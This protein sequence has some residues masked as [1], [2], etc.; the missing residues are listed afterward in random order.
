VGAPY[1][2]SAYWPEAEGQDDW[3]FCTP[4]LNIATHSDSKENSPVF[5]WVVTQYWTTKQSW[6]CQTFPVENPLNEPVDIS[7]DFVHETRTA[8]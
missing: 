6:R 4:Q 8:S 3:A 2:L 5:H 7:G 1:N